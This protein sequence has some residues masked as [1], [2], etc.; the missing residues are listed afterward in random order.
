MSPVSIIIILVLLAVLY[1]L[2]CALIPRCRRDQLRIAAEQQTV[3][4]TVTEVKDH[5]A[6][7]QQTQ[8]VKLCYTID[9]KEY[10]YYCYTRPDQYQVDQTVELL[11]HPENPKRVYLKDRFHILTENEVKLI[12]FGLGMVFLFAGFLVLGNL[13]DTMK[14]IADFSKYPLVILF[15][16]FSYWIEYRTVRK[17]VHGTGTIVYSTRDH[18]NVRVIAQF[19]ADGQIYETRAMQMP[20]KQCTREYNP[21]GQI[22]VLYAEKTPGDAVIEDDTLRLRQLHRAA[23][24][25]SVT[26][27]LFLLAMWVIYNMIFTG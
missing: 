6:G 1:A 26:V 11:R 18:K 7:G 14:E 9:G 8:R 24:I 12:I 21:G 17:G 27:P 16:W 22:G 3:S 23:I 19:E 10:T 4:G 25:V 13:N 15:A 20:I 5:R 2:L